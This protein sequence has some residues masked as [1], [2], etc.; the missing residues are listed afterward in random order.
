MGERMGLSDL[1]YPKETRGSD[2]DLDHLFRSSDDED[3]S[4]TPIMGDSND[5]GVP[6]FEPNIINRG[7]HQISW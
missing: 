5:F 1:A 7:Q 3:S 2:S 4:K 6:P